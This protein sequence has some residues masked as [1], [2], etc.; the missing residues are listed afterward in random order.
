[1]RFQGDKRW[2]TKTVLLLG[3]GLM[4]SDAAELLYR[5][6]PNFRG[7]KKCSIFEVHPEDGNGMFL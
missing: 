7:K 2:V 4:S 3:G 6:I 5:S 1:M